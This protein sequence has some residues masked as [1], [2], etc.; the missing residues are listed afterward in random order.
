MCEDEATERVESLGGTTEFNDEL[1]GKP[2]VN[3]HFDSV[4]RVSDADLVIL[5]AFEY[6]DV[7]TLDATE[8]TDAGLV[9]LAVLKSL[10]ILDL[11]RTKVT[12]AGLKL[13]AGLPGLRI[14]DLGSTA[15]TDVGVRELQAALP[16][17]EIHR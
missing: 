10:R 11:R 5:A 8:I 9:H 15:A 16:K 4:S 17:C 1:P 3:V 7:L 13:L 6:L 12:D 14:L 2:L